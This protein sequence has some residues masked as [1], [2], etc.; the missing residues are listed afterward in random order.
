MDWNAGKNDRASLGLQYEVGRQANYTDPIS[1]LFDADYSGPPWWQGRVIETH[2]FG[3]SAANQFLLAGSY[4]GNS[5]AFQLKHPSQ[6]LAVFRPTLN[7]VQG[8]FDSLATANSFS[9]FGF[10]LY[11]TQYKPSDAWKQA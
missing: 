6:A 5:G 4:G 3:V 8:T 2:T 1:P 10:G 9:A 11:E 7:F